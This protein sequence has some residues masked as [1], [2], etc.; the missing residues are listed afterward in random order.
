MEKE[1][2]VGANFLCSACT[3]KVDGLS[4]FKKLFMYVYHIQMYMVCIYNQFTTIHKGN[5]K[6]IEQV[7]HNA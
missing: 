2:K 5:S 3:Y 7:L 4:L 6:N 1:V